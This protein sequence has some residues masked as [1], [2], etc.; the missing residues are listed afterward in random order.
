MPEEIVI[1]HYRESWAED[2]KEEKRRL[3]EALE[4]NVETIEHVGS[5][6]VPGLGAKPVID[7]LIGVASLDLADRHCI[8]PIQT[9]GYE[10]V[11]RFEASLPFRR[12]FRRNDPRGKRTHQIHLVQTHSDFRGDLIL[13]RDHLRVSNGDRDRY[14]AL[15]RRLAE[16]EWQKTTHY[17]EAKGDF[18]AEVLERARSERRHGS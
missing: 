15:K 2:F 8:A 9:L 16:R 5:T 3:A 4:E 18:I 17:A 14:D 12:Y 6:S 7:I 13:F 1:E 11:N 10:Y